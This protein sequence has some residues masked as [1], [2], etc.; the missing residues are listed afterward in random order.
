MNYCVRFSPILD[1]IVRK[2]CIAPGVCFCCLLIGDDLGLLVRNF[3]VSLKC[4]KLASVNG[5]DEGMS[6]LIC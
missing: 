6:E 5:F 2:V 1:A 3:L 4:A